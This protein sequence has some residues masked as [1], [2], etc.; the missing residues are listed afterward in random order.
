[1]EPVVGWAKAR[2]ARRARVEERAD[3][4]V[5]ARTIFALIHAARLCPPYRELQHDLQT[6][7][8]GAQIERVRGARSPL[9]ARDPAGGR[10]RAAWPSPSGHDRHRDRGGHDQD[11]AGAAARRSARA[12]HA[13]PDD[14]KIQRASALARHHHLFGREPHSHLGR[15][16]RGRASRRLA[17]IG[18]RQLPW[19][20]RGRGRHRR[21][22]AARGARHAGRH[23]AMAPL[24][25]ARQRLFSRSMPI[26]ASTPATSRPR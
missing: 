17:Q 10:D 9:H 16:R 4:R 21:A 18:H 20:Q 8:G 15:D 3:A 13:R 14:R 11:G 1:M 22:R 5:H 6:L 7:L 25:P 24:R 2:L 12:V 26:T 19:R 23:H